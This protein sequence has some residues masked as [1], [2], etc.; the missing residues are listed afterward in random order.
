MFRSQTLSWLT[1]GLLLLSVVVAGCGGPADAS[2]KPLPD[3]SD[4]SD[5]ARVDEIQLQIMESFP[6]QVAVIASGNLSDGCTE[7]DEINQT[8]DDETNTFSVKITTD[9]PADAMC[10]QA[11]VP[12]EERISLEVQGLPAG[13]YTVDVNGVTDTFTLDVDN[14]IPE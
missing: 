2:E 1:V 11:L 3:K 13:T 12:F 5:L 14:V 10:T 7:I 8:F 6:V 9:R 4:P